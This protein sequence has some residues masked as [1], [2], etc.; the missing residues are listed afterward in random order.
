M[1]LSLP[2]LVQIGCLIV[3]ALLLLTAAWQD[4]RTMVIPDGLSLGIVGVFALWALAGCAGDTLSLWSAG[5]AVA[6]AVGV[7]LV[8]AI[9]FAAGMLGGGDVKLLAAS[10][11]FAGPA[12]MLDFITVVVLAGGLLGIAILAGAPIGTAAPAAAPTGEGALR[13]RLRGN[14]PYGPAIAAGGL[15]LAAVLAPT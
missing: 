10:S 12:L 8:G 4:F 3:F 9:A 11:L 14:L 15:W 13:A 1:S 7:F 6:C 2:A 5:F